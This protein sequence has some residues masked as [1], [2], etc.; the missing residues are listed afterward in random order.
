MKVANDKPSLI[1]QIKDIM[2]MLIIA[3]IIVAADQLTKTIIRG[4]LAVIG[5]LEVIKGFFEFSYS[6]NTGAAFGTFHDKNS[7]FIVVNLIAIIF[8]FIYH[9]RYKENIWMKVSLGFILGGA[10]GNLADRI[11]FGFVTD[12]IRVRL[13]FIHTFWWPN[14]NIADSGVTVGAIMLIIVLFRDS[15]KGRLED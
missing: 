2:P 4:K 1:T 14:F 12:F 13:W 11:F 9:N 6:Q 15:Y 3:I 10:L 5:T 7:I 8:I